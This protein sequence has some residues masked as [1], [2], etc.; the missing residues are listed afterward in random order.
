M[1]YGTGAKGRCGRYSAD[2][3]RTDRAFPHGGPE[4]RVLVQNA[5]DA[6]KLY[7]WTYKKYYACR[8][9]GNISGDVFKAWVEQATLGR[10]AAA[11]AHIE[12]TQNAAEK[13]QSIE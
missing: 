3:Q 1:A 2:S 10:G 4:N 5:M 12:A 6:W 11:I 9:K 7:K 8:L 13:P